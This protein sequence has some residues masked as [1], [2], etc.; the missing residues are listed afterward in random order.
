MKNSKNILKRSYTK[1]LIVALAFVVWMLFFDKHNIFRQANVSKEVTKLKQEN[2]DMASQIDSIKTF[3]DKVDSDVRT[4][5]KFA[6]EQYT[7]KREDEDV[8]L[9]IK[10]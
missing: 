2:L 10:K 4:T 7:V 8:Y 1:Y 5:E 9:I 3:N 6:R